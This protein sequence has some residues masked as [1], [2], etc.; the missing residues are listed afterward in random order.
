MKN[1]AKFSKFRGRRQ[2]S[3]FRTCRDKFLSVKKFCL[4]NCFK[5]AVRKIIDQILILI[6]IKSTPYHPHVR[7]CRTFF[8]KLSLCIVRGMV[9]VTTP[10]CPRVFPRT[11]QSLAG[12][13]VMLVAVVVL[14]YELPDVYYPSGYVNFNRFSLGRI[15]AHYF[16]QLRKIVRVI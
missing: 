3:R 13:I 5:M 10:L 12:W 8:Q 7:Y 9:Q 1:F 11:W 6:M 2:I 14:F 15:S 16:K 4:F